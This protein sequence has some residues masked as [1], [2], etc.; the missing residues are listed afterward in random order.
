MRLHSRLRWI[1]VG[2]GLGWSF[3]P[4]ASCSKN[5]MSV[6]PSYVPEGQVSPDARLIVWYDAPIQVSYYADVAPIGRS[7][8]DALREIIEVRRDPLGTVTGRIFDR[9]LATRYQ[10][11]RREASGGF[12]P[13]RDA[14]D[15]NVAQFN[16]TQWE[17]YSFKDFDPSTHAPD[18]LGRGEVAGS[19]TRNS[20]LTNTVRVGA[21][22]IGDIQFTGGRD[23][24]LTA[25]TVLRWNPV[26]GAAGYWMHI[27]QARNFD[28][29]SDILNAAP[30]VIYDGPSPDLFLGFFRDTLGY[31]LRDSLRTDVE[32]ITS[33]PVIPGQ[34]YLIRVSAV[35]AKGQLIAYTY[36]DTSRNR[37]SGVER[38]YVIYPV[39]AVEIPRFVPGAALTSILPSAGENPT[40]IRSPAR[41]SPQFSRLRRN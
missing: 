38:V 21:G 40:S 27:Y 34:S 13:L 30:S 17:I 15:R 4:L 5:L 11:L 6:D 28:L 33:Q 23:S 12:L 31:R 24:A 19:I 32:V 37:P 39:G 3:L 41:R 25:S 20:P 18:Y 16:D 14:L 29:A 26:P 22:P 10:V 36:G 35:N 7:A 1:L 9:T 8:D 2:A